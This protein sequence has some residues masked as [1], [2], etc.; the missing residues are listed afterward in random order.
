MI[1]KHANSKHKLKPLNLFIYGGAG[2]GKSFLV[3]AIVNELDDKVSVN[4]TTGVSAFHIGGATIDSALKLH[5]NN[6]SP[7]VLREL[8][9]NLKNIKYIIIDE[10]SMMGQRKLLNLSNRLKEIKVEEVYGGG[11]VDFSE[12]AI[13]SR[14]PPSD[15]FFVS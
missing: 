10:M 8:Q 15:L 14:N 11:L 2:A 12:F 13:F 7:Q 3:D 9:E 5:V 4:A 1:K 6:I